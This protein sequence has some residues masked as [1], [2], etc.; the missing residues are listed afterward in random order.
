M[1][2]KSNYLPA[3]E[4]YRRLLNIA[5]IRF[6]LSMDQCRDKFGLYTALDWENLLSK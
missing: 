2:N 5:S 1:E 6:N 3:C 4:E